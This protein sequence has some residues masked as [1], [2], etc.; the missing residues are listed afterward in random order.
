MDTDEFE[1]FWAKTED[2]DN[3]DARQAKALHRTIE[4]TNAMWGHRLSDAFSKGKLPF[5]GPDAMM[6][7][8]SSVVRI[9][10]ALMARDMPMLTS[11]CYD[12]GLGELA[13]MVRDDPE[14]QQVVPIVSVADLAAFHR[15]KL[16]EEGR[17]GGPL[18]VEDILRETT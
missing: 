9:H 10:M 1:E 6:A 14:L 3:P 4:I 8:A 18:F 12:A 2:P 11:E 15:M 13:E 17:K 5:D 7:F 16:R